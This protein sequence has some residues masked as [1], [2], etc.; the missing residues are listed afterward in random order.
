MK[1]KENS[2]ILILTLIL[3]LSTVSI[4]PKQVTSWP[5]VSYTSELEQHNT[6]PKIVFSE[7]YYDAIGTDSDKEY[8][9]LYNPTEIEINIANWKIEDNNYLYSISGIS[10]VKPY[11]YFTIARDSTEFY[12]DYGTLPDR[13]DLTLALNNDGDYLTLYDN[14]GI[15]IDFV[16]WEG[17][18]TGW[19]IKA[20][21]GLTIQRQNPNEDTDASS[22]WLDNQP[23]DPKTQASGSFPP[24]VNLPPEAVTLFPPLKVTTTTIT[25]RWT[26]NNDSDFDRYQITVENSSS[27]FAFSDTNLGQQSTTQTKITDLAPNTTYEISVDVYDTGGLSNESNVITVKTLEKPTQPDNGDTSNGNEDTGDETGDNESDSQ[28]SGKDDWLYGLGFILVIVFIL[29]GT[30]YWVKKRRK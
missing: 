4:I 9:E 16:A 12:N 17:A 30:F 13:G 29:I 14:T 22:D 15:E 3:L 25:I 10:T 1:I 6:E 7:I 8:I 11:S 24:S 27:G 28:T 2:T 23:R 18:A 26:Q 5:N 20:T 19:N 21:E